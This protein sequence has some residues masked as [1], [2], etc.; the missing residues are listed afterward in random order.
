MKMTNPLYH[1]T[2]QAG[3]LGILKSRQLWMTNILYLNDST[4]FTHTIDLVK[5]ELNDRRKSLI[6]NGGLRAIVLNGNY[7]IN[8]KQLQALER[9]ER[10][11]DGFNTEVRTSSFVFS[12]SEREDDLSQWRGYC[13]NTGGFC[14]QFNDELSSIVNNKAGYKIEECKYD[15]EE[16]KKLVKSIFDDSLFGSNRSWTIEESVLKLIQKMVGIA[17]YLKDNS[18]KEE[19]EHRI[20]YNTM[21][22]REIMYREGKSMFIPYFEGEFVDNNGKLPLSKIIVGPTPHKE[23]SKISV[24]YLLETYGYDIEIECSNIPYRSW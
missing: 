24:R 20:V 17:P 15:P 9:L 14:I 6:N 23:L 19:K 13:P 16:K 4:E 3:L 21:N 22:E 1:Y 5:T 8:E 12:L 18:F 2:S 7:N 10:I 11:L